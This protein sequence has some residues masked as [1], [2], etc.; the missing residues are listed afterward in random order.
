MLEFVDLMR[1]KGGNPNEF[2]AWSDATPEQNLFLEGLLALPCHLICS[3]RAKTA[4]VLEEK[5]RRDGG[6]YSAP[7]RVGLKPIQREG[8]E[9][10]FTT[11]MDL[12][13]DTK[14][15]TVSKDRTTLFVD[16]ATL[17]SKRF[18]LTEEVGKEL[19]RWLYQGEA[20][21][22]V[23]PV[24]V[25]ERAQAA[26][27]QAIR[28]ME[29]CRNQPDM[30]KAYGAGQE[31]IRGFA[32]TLDLEIING[33]FAELA[34]AKDRCKALLGGNG[35]RAQE[36]ARAGGSATLN[37]GLPEAARRRAGGSK[38]DDMEDDVPF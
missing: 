23:A 3:M 9:Y 36:D 12:E 5:T 7:R 38:F 14:T 27:Q 19:A 1:R 35:T 34:A 29:A 10:E 28:A 4:Y 6:K 24:P 33:L 26:L 30:A 21:P 22:A 25:L 32:S 8:V 17:Q 20:A 11:V 2:A 18:V 13:L 31:T 16:P 37:D 15:A